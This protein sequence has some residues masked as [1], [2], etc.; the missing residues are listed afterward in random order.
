MEYCQ[1]YTNSQHTQFDLWH[2]SAQKDKSIEEH[3]AYIL[4]KAQIAFH[5]A[6]PE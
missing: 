3:Y 5:E 4:N 1:P 6:L 2:N